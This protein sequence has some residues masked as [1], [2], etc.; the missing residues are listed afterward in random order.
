MNTSIHL[1]RINMRFV[2]IVSR[3]AVLLVASMAPVWPSLAATGSV[4]ARFELGAPQG[5]PFPSNRFT[6]PD[7]SQNTGI[8]VELPKSDCAAHPSDCADLDVINE[9]DGF[10][11]QPRLSIPFDGPIDV[12]SVTSESVFLVRLGST[13]PGGNP[14]GR[15][16]GI[17]QVVWDTFTNALHV[18][19]DELLDQHT[20]YVLVVTKKVMD[21]GGKEVK[22]AK[23]FLDFVDESNSASTGDPA[24]DAYRTLLR[25]ALTQIDATGVIPRGQVV[26][27][28]VFTTQSVT[29][30]LEKIRDQIKAATPAPADFLLGPGTSRTVFAR[31]TMM[32]VRLNA[33]VSA[34]PT[35]PLS[36][37]PL[38]LSVLNVVPGAV[39]TIAFGKYSSPDYR[40]HPGEFIPAVGTKFGTPVVQGSS[41]VGFILFL[42]SS[43]EPATG[44]PV[45]IFGHGAGGN[46]AESGFVAAKLAQQGI[47]VIA[48]DQPGNGFGPLSTYTIGFTDLSSVTFPS[49]GRGIDQN[50][51]GQIGQSEGFSAARPRTILG[52]RDG[53][54]QTVIDHMQLVR[55]IEVGMDV[56]GGGL[57]DLDPSRIYYLGPS[58]GGI[59][60]LPFLAIEPDV[61]A[62]IFT[63]PGGSGEFRLAA[64]S[65]G[66]P[67]A[68]LQARVPSLINSPGI[69]RLDG[70]P[71]LPPYFNENMPL[72]SGAAFTALLQ[73]GTTQVIRSPLI[74][75]IPG[76][77]DIQQVIENGEWASQAGDA[78]AYAAYIRRKPLGGVPA[79][80]V[81]V[82]FANGDRVVPNPTTTAILRAGDLADRAT[83]VRTNLVFPVNPRPFP[84]NIYLYPHAFLQIFADPALTAIAL[85][86]QQQIASFFALDGTNQNLNPFDGTQILDPDG[87]SPVFEVPIVPPLP[88]ALNY[89]P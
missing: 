26:A 7:S 70:L 28:S 4:H 83:F 40:V 72:R 14:G 86:A 13:L 62:G 38:P 78:V 21:A 69:T 48:I 66:D 71:V 73:D 60:G 2:L 6:V 50:G 45:A 85:Q 42:P 68:S 64:S 59:Q 51:D 43:P 1:P 56:D 9:L 63:V 57:P 89:F 23:V 3:I 44:Y 8:R 65:R 11:L 12:A 80:A 88:E 77:M 54:R 22:A 20:R 27:A 34:D 16:V 36:T 61:R 5:E 58:R 10:N 24:L 32:S 47:A 39:G 15:V 76:A 31:S 30:I 25:N 33:Q 35:A 79:K 67:G 37:L 81:I 52:G 55:E 19:S 41:D 18:E 46:K 87:A 53:Q 74:N 49:V 17:N 29:A 75:T 84:N 82:Q